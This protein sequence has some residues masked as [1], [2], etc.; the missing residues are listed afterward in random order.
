MQKKSN[1]PF[2]GIY[3]CACEQKEITVFNN[4]AEMNTLPAPKVFL[5]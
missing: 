1:L 3:I 2:T 4:S 5:N